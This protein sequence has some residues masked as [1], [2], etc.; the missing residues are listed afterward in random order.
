MKFA[1]MHEISPI[2]HKL[3]HMHFPPEKL[4]WTIDQALTRSEPSDPGA[5]TIFRRSKYLF[6]PC[7]FAKAKSLLEGFRGLWVCAFLICPMVIY[8]MRWLFEHF[9]IYIPW[10][11][12][13]ISRNKERVM[14]YACEL[15]TWTLI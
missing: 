7:A 3:N 5:C 4:I 13:N 11:F 1:A 9:T 15:C 10:K 14:K 6:F 2:S 12:H 8:H